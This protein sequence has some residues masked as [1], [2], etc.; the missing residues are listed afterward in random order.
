MKFRELLRKLFIALSVVL[1]AL[2]RRE[3]EDIF[4]FY[5]VLFV[6]FHY[7]LDVVVCARIFCEM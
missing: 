5:G 3:E 2:A 6:S 4:I 7:R 1:M